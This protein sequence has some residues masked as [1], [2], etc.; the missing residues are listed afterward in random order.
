MAYDMKNSELLEKLIDYAKKIG[1]ENTSLTAERLLVAICDFVDGTSELDIYDDTSK[2]NLDKMLSEAGLQSS[3]IRGVL[4]EQIKKEPEKTIAGDIYIRS[5][6]YEAKAE[7]QKHSM[8]ELTPELLLKCV[9]NAPTEFIQ[10][11]KKGEKKIELPDMGRLSQGSESNG[12]SAGNASDSSEDNIFSIMK[13]AKEAGEQLRKTV[14]GQDTAISVFMSGYFRAKMQ[15][16]TDKK[17]K[18]PLATFLFAGPPGVGKTFLAEQAAKALNIKDFIRFDM[19]EYSDHEASVEFCGSDGVYKQSKPG[20]VTGY[21]AQHPKCVILFD[22][23]EKAHISIIHLFLQMLD[24]G[25]VRDN[26]TDKE[27]SF[28]DAIVILTTNAGRQ[29]YEQAEGKLSDLPR[30]VVLNALKNDINPLTGNSFFP[31]AI[32]SRLATGNVVM[33]NHI[34]AHDLYQIVKKELLYH[35]EGFKDKFDINVTVDDNVYSALMF[36]EGGAA[37]ARMTNGRVTGFFEEEMFELFRLVDPDNLPDRIELIKN[38]NMTVRLPDPSSKIYSLFKN[39]EKPEVLLFSSGNTAAVCEQS[40][41]DCKLLCAQDAENAK[42]LLRGNIKLC[43]IDI[44]YGITGE[45]SGLLNAEDRDSKARSFLRYVREYYRDLP[46][47]IILS[48]GFRLNHEEE[49][50]FIKLGVRGIIDLNDKPEEFGSELL[51]ICGFIHQQDSMNFLARSNQVI[52]FETAQTISADG[53]D[54]EIQLFDFKMTAAVDAEDSKDI[55]SNVSKPDVH[56][57]DVIGAEG[58]KKELK[59]FVECL[60][61]PKKFRDTGVK[62]P[63]GVILYGPPGTG[64]TMLAK[65]MACESDVTFISAEGNQFIQKYIGDG[66]RRMHELFNTARKYAPSIIFIDEIDAIAKERRGGEH[67]TAN[68]EDVL[69][70]LLAEMDGF[71]TD[72][73]KPVFVLAATN[74]NA[75]PGNDKSLDPALL[76]RFDRKVYIEL[77]NRDERIK[78]LK[79][80]LAAN[81]LFNISED[82]ITNI[83]IRSTGMSLADLESVIELALR[84]AIRDGKTSIEGDDF[85]EAFE[86]AMSGDAK[87]PDVANLERIARHEAGHAYLCRLSGEKPSYLTIVARGNYGGYMQHD[88]NEDK[89]IFTK[90]E[91]LAHICTSLGGRA[92]EIVYYGEKDG[93]ST[94]ASSDLA[95]ATAMAQNIICKYGMDNS[96]GLAVIDSQAARMGELSSDVRSAVNAILAEQMS[97]ATELITKGRPAIDRLVEELMI[98]NHLTGDEIDKLLSSFD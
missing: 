82:E 23:I 84:N 22:E 10:G 73:T 50:S 14:F 66:S 13:T 68:G 16:L 92:S 62:A 53:K 60:R 72:T 79:M 1:N 33:F 27:V 43:L 45:N 25:R 51:K 81:K 71:K 78:Y 86:T 97:K 63:R 34:E 49:L 75:D 42:K 47:Y 3:K 59:Y 67:A 96:F 94:G 88:D 4:I 2:V 36:E 8:S 20:N 52:S 32:C 74:F 38:I 31:P 76:R 28:K 90:E 87:K 9:L 40:A 19:S 7:A 57:D 21:V 55:I 39:C 91:L 85:F 29:R 83:A 41:R 17:R 64:K 30:K 48:D 95:N 77:P 70:A 12:N 98:K 69:T 46:V 26:N 89:S 54:A 65:A 35:A 56:F 5:R 80:K 15:A 37:D 44:G 61:N 6:M 18:G 93:I 58:A 24:A 11:L